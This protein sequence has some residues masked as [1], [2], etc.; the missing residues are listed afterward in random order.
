MWIAVPLM[1]TKP[2]KGVRFFRKEA[3]MRIRQSKEK[4][5]AEIIMDR[6]F[7]VFDLPLRERLLLVRHLM[8]KGTQ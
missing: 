6:R 4:E 5:V 8:Q 3:L 7:Y 1:E 2:A